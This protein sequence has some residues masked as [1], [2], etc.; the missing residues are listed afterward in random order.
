[1]EFTR[2]AIGVCSAGVVLAACGLVFGRPVLAFGA[3]GV[4][5]W[6]LGHLRAFVRAAARTDRSLVVRARPSQTT[7][8]VDQAV[9]VV[10]TV[11]LE[12]PSP[13]SL[14]V[15]PNAPMVASIRNSTPRHLEP[16]ATGAD[17]TYEVTFPVAGVYELAPATV[18]LRDDKGLFKTQ[19][20]RGD[21]PEIAVDSRVPSGMHVGRGGRDVAESYDGQRGQT[22][23]RGIEPQE[24]REYVPGDETKNI[25][26]NAT[27]RHDE[28]YIRQF[29]TSRD[30]RGV[31]VVDLSSSMDTGQPG[32]T[33]L[34]YAREVALGFVESAA[35][36][37]DSLTLYGVDDDE[38]LTRHETES[39]GESLARLRAPLLE[40][41]SS[42]S[43][44]ASA[45]QRSYTSPVSRRRL[46]RQLRA[47]ETTFDERL[48]PFFGSQPRIESQDDDPIRTAINRERVHTE[49]ELSVVLVTDDTDSDRLW[50]N[51]QYAHRAAADVTVFLTPHVLFEP[52]GLS[53]IERA[54]ERYRTFEDL[55]CELD[56][57]PSVA[58]YE[59][60][61]GDRFATVLGAAQ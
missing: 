28:L 46:A 2:R 48:S 50:G 35:S 10:Q 13:L 18:E 53:D 12:G 54:Y 42:G 30:R 9:G 16:D 56:R 59:V 44:T 37:F 47:G 32:E 61:P 23:L 7:V 26:W 21:R 8:S 34:A 52:G 5:A 20:E 57:L 24:I 6:F 33:K 3:V 11:E 43:Q 15:T 14:S 31:I 41:G 55:R 4:G 45:P 60:G 27:A 22:A 17:L 1:M 25:D 19:I 38:I 51:V 29:E 58:A 36:Q 40:F 49:D 39:T